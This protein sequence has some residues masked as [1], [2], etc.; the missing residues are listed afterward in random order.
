VPGSADSAALAEA[1]QRIQRLLDAANQ[2]SATI[3]RTERLAQ[4]S[5]EALSTGAALNLARPVNGSHNRPTAWLTIEQAAARTGRHP[6]LLR[7]WC[8]GGRIEATR[9]GRQWLLADSDL[10]SVERLPSRQPRSAS[11]AR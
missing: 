3:E 8:A 10:W 2:L 7:R 6:D 5:A 1:G 11:R 9:V 4:Q